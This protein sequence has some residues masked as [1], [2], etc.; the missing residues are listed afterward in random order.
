[1]DEEFFMAVLRY[2]QEDGEHIKGVLLYRGSKLVEIYLHPDFDDDHWTLMQING[3]DVSGN[4]DAV[5]KVSREGG[6]IQADLDRAPETFQS[7]KHLN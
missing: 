5:E 7:V 2:T 3:F 1:M 4:I 6:L